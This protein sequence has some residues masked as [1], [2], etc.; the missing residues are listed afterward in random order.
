MDFN[1]NEENNDFMFSIP[2]S[3]NHTILIFFSLMKIPLTLGLFNFLG[4]TTH[5]RKYPTN[6]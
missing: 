4:D 3:S 1:V 5:K 2:S 6:M